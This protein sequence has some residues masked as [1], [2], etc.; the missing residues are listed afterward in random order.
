MHITIYNYII[1]P[2]PPE[3]QRQ[4]DGLSNLEYLAWLTLMAMESREARRPEPPA[5]VPPPPPPPPP[6]LPPPPPP[7]PL[8]R[9]LPSP[10][11]VYAPQAVSEVQLIPGL[12]HPGSGKIY[13][14]Q[15]GAY[16]SLD[17]ASRA[18]QLVRAAGFDAVYE[19]SGNVYRVY[20]SNIPAQSVYYAAQR[21]GVMGF[22]Q[23]WV[24]E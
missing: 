24:R 3:R 21:L 10:P 23:I 13:S 7:Q 16:N 8:P 11:P 18:F 15:V 20:A 6:P 4:E 12:P 14:L 2:D 1:N 9:V 22:G 19:Q 5:P 17:S